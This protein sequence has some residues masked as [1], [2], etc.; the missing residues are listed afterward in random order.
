MT[1]FII[2]TCINFFLLCL[3]HLN[4]W[5]P[6]SFSILGIIQSRYTQFM[7]ITASMVVALMWIK[8]TGSMPTAEMVY[9]VIHGDGP[10]ESVRAEY[11]FNWLSFIFYEVIAWAFLLYFAN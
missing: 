6:I 10:P 5:R 7:Q 3:A 2:F 9:R 11:Q 4:T 8:R 1:I